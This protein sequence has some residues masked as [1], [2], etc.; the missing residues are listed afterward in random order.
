MHEPR[1]SWGPRVGPK[2]AEFPRASDWLNHWITFSRLSPPTPPQHS[3]DLHYAHA[4]Y[5]GARRWLSADLRRVSWPM[6]PPR[7][8]SSYRDPPW[9]P[10]PW[11]SFSLRLVDPPRAQRSSLRERHLERL[12]CWL[13]SPRPR[14]LPFLIPERKEITDCSTGTDPAALCS[15]WFLT[16]S[17]VNYK[18]QSF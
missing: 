17:S 7:S 9:S 14:H 2:F 8:S 13:W 12:G 10:T 1:R 15:P 11:S 5:S 3:P 6:G 18:K 4:W 16:L